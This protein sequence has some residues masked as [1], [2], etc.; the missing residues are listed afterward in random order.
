MVAASILSSPC[1]FHAV[2]RAASLFAPGR[3]CQGLICHFFKRRLQALLPSLCV[4][5]GV[6]RPTLTDRDGFFVLFAV[7][8][9]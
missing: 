7:V 2:V 3:S 4:F 1:N 8:L 6:I 5:A 9:L